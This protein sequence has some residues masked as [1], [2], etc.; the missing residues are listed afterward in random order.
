MAPKDKSGKETQNLALTW[1]SCQWWFPQRFLNLLLKKKSLAPLV[2]STHWLKLTCWWTV[3][4]SFEENPFL[5]LMIHEGLSL[6]TKFSKYTSISLVRRQI[7][8][9]YSYIILINYL[10]I[11]APNGTS[12]SIKRDTYIIKNVSLIKIRFY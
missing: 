3:G 10:K 4:I 9:N 12:S 5:G 2:F 1:D 8:R 6:G 7:C 11:G